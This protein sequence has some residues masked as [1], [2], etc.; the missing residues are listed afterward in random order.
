LPLVGHFG[1]DFVSAQ[2]G[3][4]LTIDDLAG[5]LRIPKSTLYKLVREGAIPCQKIGKHWRFH[6]SA[7]DQW[8]AN[9]YCTDSAATEH[10]ERTS[11]QNH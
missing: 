10:D 8:L 7:I 9:G 11:G 1:G 4:I 5:Y 3:E 2:Q 6:K